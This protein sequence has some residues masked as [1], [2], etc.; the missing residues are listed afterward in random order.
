MIRQRARFRPEGQPPASSA[1]SSSLFSAASAGECLESICSEV[2]PRQVLLHS[3]G[4]APGVFQG[5]PWKRPAR[6]LE[7]RGRTGL[8]GREACGG[9]AAGRSESPPE[10]PEAGRRPSTAAVGPVGACA[11]AA[12]RQ[13][14]AVA[15]A[16]ATG[17]PHVA[18]AMNG[19][20]DIAAAVAVVSRPHGCG[21]GPQ[22]ERNAGAGMIALETRLPVTEPPGGTRTAAAH[23]ARRGTV[24]CCPARGAPGMRQVGL[25]DR[26][27]LIP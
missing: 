15:V 11:T 18:V 7:S 19:R 20:G 2:W 21:R 5:R 14:P 24:C 16:V 6:R 9:A 10:A 25:N 1:T 8:L 3:Q 4:R 23:P 12:G 13:W 17:Q 27:R 22:P 26:A